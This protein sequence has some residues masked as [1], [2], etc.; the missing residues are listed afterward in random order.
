MAEAV[1]AP[2]QILGGFQ[3]NAAMKS[4]ARAKEYEAGISDLRAA[5]IAGDRRAELNDALA[6]LDVIRASRNVNPDSP[7][8]RAFE[9]RL[10]Q[11]S[12]DAE[13]REVLGERVR[14][15]GLRTEARDAR[16]AGTAAMIGGIGQGLS[17][18]AGY[19]SGKGWI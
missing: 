14:G 8:A 13:T 1:A 12:L 10:K 5:Q 3:R 6:A 4:Q 11:D 18:F 19:A 2:F 7:T 17:S 9:D 16:R 15:V